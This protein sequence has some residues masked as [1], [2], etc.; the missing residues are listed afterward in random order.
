MLVAGTHRHRQDDN[1]SMMLNNS[2]TAINTRKR[3]D[4]DLESEATMTNFTTN[5]RL[6]TRSVF[7]ISGM[8]DDKD[9][10][11]F[12]LTNDSVND[13]TKLPLLFDSDSD[14]DNDN[15]SDGSSRKRKRKR[16]GNL[17]DLLNNDGITDDDTLRFI[18][19]LPEKEK[20]RL[21]KELSKKSKK[22]KKHKNKNKN[23]MKQNKRNRHSKHSKHNK[24]DK[25]NKKNKSKSK[26]KKKQQQ[27]Q[28]E[29]W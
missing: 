3:E 29:L 28:Q 27:Q 23:K 16:K 20:M 4:E 5:N 25:N 2:Q 14:R 18:Q 12:K 24:K 17:N 9:A 19:S 21:L 7:T 26:K 13:G 1:M 15:S 6:E 11:Y 10:R 8:K 22:S